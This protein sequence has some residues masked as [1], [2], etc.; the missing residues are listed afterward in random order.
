MVIEIRAVLKINEIGTY[1]ES[2]ELQ[3][4]FSWF[5]IK[6]LIEGIKFP[7]NNVSLDVNVKCNHCGYKGHRGK[8]CIYSSH[9]VAY[10]IDDYIENK[11]NA[12]PIKLK[13]NVEDNSIL[14]VKRVPLHEAKV[15]YPANELHEYCAKRFDHLLLM[16][17]LYNEKKRKYDGNGHTVPPDTYTCH[18][19]GISGHWRENCPQTSSDLHDKDSKED[20]KEDGT[21]SRY[22][23]TKS[24]PPNSYT[25]HTCGTPGHWRENCPTTIPEKVEKSQCVEKVQ[26]TQSQ[27]TLVSALPCTFCK[28]EY[29]TRK[30]CPIGPVII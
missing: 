22:K 9:Y 13:D 23:K 3:E 26:T 25:C 16:K 19:C 11:N 28:S 4:D 20:S 15:I 27:D 6:K 5:N 12:T 24:I 30:K 8:A 7:A 21:R 2:T 14:V 10:Y 1:I 17:A 18:T 29:H